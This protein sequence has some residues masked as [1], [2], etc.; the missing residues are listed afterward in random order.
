MATAI[1][2]ATHQRSG[3][4]PRD[5]DSG[6]RRR[7][8]SVWLPHRTRR[9][10]GQTKANAAT[11]ATGQCRGTAIGRMQRQRRHH[12]AASPI[13]E[14]T[15]VWWSVGG[16]GAEG[17]SGRP[18][19]ASSFEEATGSPLPYFDVDVRNEIL[20]NCRCDL[21][22]LATIVD[23]LNYFTSYKFQKPVFMNAWILF[24]GNKGSESAWSMDTFEF[25]DTSYHQ[26]P[27]H[28]EILYPL[29]VRASHRWLVRTPVFSLIATL[30]AIFTTFQ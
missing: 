21:T 2:T 6:R 26:T 15:D 13:E 1:S 8:R 19:A 16:E 23:D 7:L 10:H 22:H 29:C 28:L 30:W 9:T 12:R 4:V 18:R 17:L 14:E 25:T 20:V 24:L 5:R 3:P 11:T 27:R